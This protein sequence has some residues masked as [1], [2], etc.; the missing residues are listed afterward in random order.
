MAF[1]ECTEYPAD[2]Q[3]ARASMEL[4]LPGRALQELLRSAQP[5]SSVG[6]SGR[7]APDAFVRGG[8]RSS[9]EAGATQ[10]LFGIVQGGMDRDLRR[11]IRRAHHRHRL[12]DTPSVASALA[13]HANLLAISSCPR[14]ASS[15]DQAAISDGRRHPRRNR[16]VCAIGRRHDGL[17]FFRRAPP[18]RLAVHL[19]GQ[20]VDQASALRAG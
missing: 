16:A 19:R 5:R 4:T 11:E 8:E 15:R 13:N 12:P 14:R 20:G 18:P 3:R 9:P 1:D 10:S 2:A 7:I 17:C 6:G